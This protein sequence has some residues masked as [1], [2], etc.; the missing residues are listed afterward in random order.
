MKPTQRTRLQSLTRSALIAG[1]IA[2]L[3]VAFGWTRPW[4]GLEERAQALL[5]SA[6]APRP[7]NSQVLVIEVDDQSLRELG[8]P[9]RRDVYAQIVT[10]AS[11]AGARVAAF[12]TFFTDPSKDP[13]DDLTLATAAADWGQVVLAAQ[14]VQSVAATDRMPALLATMGATP[15]QHCSGFQFP[16]DK[17]SNSVTLAHVDPLESAVGVS[18][19]SHWWLESRGRRLPALALAA[20]ARA[21]GIAPADIR[22]EPDFFVVGASTFPVN[23]NATAITT[24]RDLPAENRR[25]LGWFLSEL[26]SSPGSLR[27]LLKD[28]YLVIGQTAAP[29]GAEAGGAPALPRVAV[30]AALLSDLLEGQTMREA[31]PATSALLVL[32]LIVLGVAIALRLRP[33]L[34]LVGVTIVLVGFLAS[35]LWAV[36]QGWVVSPLGPLLGGVL[37]FA[38]ALGTRL[39]AQRDERQLLRNAFEPYVDPSVLGQLLEDPERYLALGGAKKNLTVLFC[40]IKGYTGASNELSAEQVVQSLREFL[41]AMTQVVKKHHGRIDKVMGD[42]IFAVFGDPIP[43]PDHPRHG[44]TV[45]MEMLEEVGRLQRLWATQGKTGI[46]IRIGVASGEA[47]VGN[48]GAVDAKLE[49]SVLGPTVNLASRL[50]GKAPPGGMLVSEE[51]YQ[52]CRGHYSFH[53]IGGLELKGFTD[54]TKAWLFVGSGLEGDPER[55]SPRLP[56][57]AP[58]LIRLAGQTVP[59]MVENVSAGGLYVIAQATAHAGDPIELEFPPSSHL[60]AAVIVRAEVRHVAPRD[61]GQHG[62]GVRIERADAQRGDDLRHFVALYLGP[63]PDGGKVDSGGDT[64]RLELGE[65]YGRLIKEKPS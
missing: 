2:I 5:M 63:Q 1:A 58:V 41:E 43:H 10:T 59:G 20:F 56:T 36:G 60:A 52:A 45:G 47:F 49:Y 30:Q 62:F 29:V 26:K 42:G 65:A 25:S 11:G 28:K 54:S 9:V 61:D 15:A 51:T 13:A 64:F 35:C 27:A 14:C 39:I 44:V 7:W 34:A 18:R 32:L 55:F 21:N 23:S 50:E 31:S 24:H 16:A 22:Q 17:L 33:A 6:R 3:T 4:R 48:L 8:W 38:G 53:S 57:L 19:G 37:A 40:G 46:A 12:D